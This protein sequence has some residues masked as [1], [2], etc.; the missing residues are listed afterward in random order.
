M[1]GLH[2]TAEI[3][4]STESLIRPAAF[5]GATQPSQGTLALR[6][7][8]KKKEGSPLP[9]KEQRDWLFLKPL[10]HIVMQ[11]K[12]QRRSLR[13]TRPRASKLRDWVVF[14]SVC[15]RHVDIVVV[16]MA[17]FAIVFAKVEESIFIICQGFL[18]AVVEL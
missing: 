7:V 11:A 2:V 8:K 14:L 18:E 4:V 13:L 12:P 3:C 9:P 1:H 10:L 16:G 6:L 15:L 5:G 17:S